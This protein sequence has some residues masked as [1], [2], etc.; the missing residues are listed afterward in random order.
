M[1][2]TERVIK[3]LQIA[4]GEVDDWKKPLLQEA[5]EVIRYHKEKADR[6]MDNLQ[7]VLDERTES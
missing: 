6:M 1:D 4:I 2:K 5:I 7:A 3:G